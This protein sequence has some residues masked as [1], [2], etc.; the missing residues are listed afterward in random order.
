M[1]VSGAELLDAA[2]LHGGGEPPLAPVIERS[3]ELK[4]ALVDF[5]LSPRFEQHLEQFMLEAADP[6]QELSEGAA[7][8]VI[9]RF[10]L[11]HRFPNGK[12]MVDQFLADRP[13]LT[14]ADRE[15]LRGWRAP[16]E[17]IFEI[18]RMNRDSLVLL[19]LLDDLEYR[20]YSNMGPAPFRRLDKAGFL[21][22]RLVP[23]CPVP[24]AW[25]ISGS[26]SAYRKSDAAQVAQ[27]ALAVATERPELVYRNPESVERAWTLMRED[28][29]AF[30]EFFGGDELVLPPDEAEERL[31]AYYRHRQ[32]AVLA[33]QPARRRPQNLPGVDAPAF[34]LAPELADAG[35]AGLIYDE[36]DGLNV[37]NE[38]GML[39]ALFADP[40]LAADKQH[41]DV[42]LG[43]LQ[44]QTIAPLPFRRLAAAHPDTVD[45]VFRKVLRKPNFTWAEH[46]EVLMRR[47]KPWYYEREPSPGIAVIGARLSELLGL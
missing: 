33:R 40:A 5:A 7:I 29:A 4:R 28:R 19:N 23:I 45:A 25:L 13:D 18:H 2:R 34:K 41:R 15:M 26:M 44:S 46:G 22:V 20:V 42:L 43:Y 24:G 9:D 31:N 37:Y 10:A 35:T 1:A 17:G 39:R 47:R 11:Q 8:G 27:V 21:L 36:T 14:E 30:V 32:E 16:V 6:Y 38:Y 3:S 12:T